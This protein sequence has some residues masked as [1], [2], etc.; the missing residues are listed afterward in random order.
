MNKRL[1]TLAL[2]VALLTAGTALAQNTIRCESQDNRYHECTYNGF[3]SVSLSRQISGTRCVE[4][5]TWGVRDNVIWVDDG[6]RADFVVFRRGGRTLR[7][8]TT[9]LICESQ[10]GRRAQCTVNTAGGV[11]LS[12]QL[13]HDSCIEGKTWGYT[14]R[15]IWVDR[16]CRA[17]FLVGTNFRGPGS[18]RNR[19]RSGGLSTYAQTI[20]CESNNNRRNHCAADTVGGV[21]LTRKLSDHSCTFNR[22]WGYDSSGIW[23]ANGCRAEFR[24][25]GGYDSMPPYSSYTDAVTC[26]SINGRRSYCQA[27]TRFGVQIGRQLSDAS[28]IFNRDWGYDAGGIWVRNGCRAEFFTGR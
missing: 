9:S 3:G 20:T 17:E 24:V 13:S 22:D 21:D 28:C 10:N 12:R 25:G 27:D 6:C 18:L 14:E 5:Q 11:A 1:G 16:G 2:A 15:G 7:Q 4:G 8:R 23:V 26:E 19:N